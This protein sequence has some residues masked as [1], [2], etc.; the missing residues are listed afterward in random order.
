MKEKMDPKAEA[1]Y[2]VQNSL[3][4]EAIIKA[5]RSQSERDVREIPKQEE[6]EKAA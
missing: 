1:L 4:F 3:Y 5:A 2:F 6:E